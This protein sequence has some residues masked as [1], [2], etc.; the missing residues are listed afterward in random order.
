MVFRCFALRCFDVSPFGGT[1]FGEESRCALPVYSGNVGRMSHSM[2]QITDPDQNLLARKLKAISWI[3][4]LTPEEIA[5]VKPLASLRRVSLLPDIK[6]WGVRFYL[7][8]AQRSFG[9][10]DDRLAAAR[11]ADM[12]RGFF[13]R[14]RTRGV[15]DPVA[16]ELNLSPARLESDLKNERHAV[17]LLKE[18]EAHLLKLGVIITAAEREAQIKDRKE[19]GR[20]N[21]T[22][23]GAFEIMGHQWTQQ[24]EGITSRLDNLAIKASGRADQLAALHLRLDGMEVKL[25][26]LEKKFDRIL[27]LAQSQATA[28]G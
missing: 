22:M 5:R 4:P 20:L 13:W 21:R 9:Y 23:A 7:G 12:V 2:L 27:A 15:G 18:M 25:D 6:T 14:Y 11:F 24:L 19:G 1:R 16:G 3:D 26:N 17:G 10:T 28:K 8:G